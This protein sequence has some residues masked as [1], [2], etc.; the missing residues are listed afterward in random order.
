MATPEAKPNRPAPSVDGCGHDLDGFLRG[1]LPRG[2]VRALVRHLLTGCP[3][4]LRVTC[5][6]WDLSQG[7]NPFMA[8]VDAAQEQ[9][10]EI[11]GELEAVKFRL[12]G[13]QACLTE[14]AAD[15]TVRDLVEDVEVMDLPTEI[16]SVIGCVL[17]DCVAPAIRDLRD[18]AALPAA[19]PEGEGT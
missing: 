10:W 18:V 11:V 12:L 1:A 14:T 15:S 4:C 6:A 19:D 17:S 8:D 5:R 16:R 7:R 13:V 3:A 9:L 2:A